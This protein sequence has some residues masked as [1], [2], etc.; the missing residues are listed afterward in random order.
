MTLSEL[1]PFFNPKGVVIV[2]A[3]RE[4]TKLGYGLARNLV[5]CGYSGGIHFVN[6]KG[7]TLLGRPIYPSVSQVPDPVDLAVLLTPPPFVPALLEECGQRGIRAAIVASGGFRETGPEGAALEKRCL[8]TARRYGIRFVGPNCVGTMDTHLPV[9]TTFLQPPMPAK[10]EVAFISHSGAIVAAIIDWLRG[11][12]IGLSRLASLGNQTDVNET[13]MLEL[14]AEDAHTRVITLYLESL[15]NGPR[16]IQTAR[17]VT[18]LKPVIALKVGRFESG[19]KAAASHTGALAGSESAFDAAFRQSGVLRASTTEEMFQWARALAWCPLPAG[20]ATAVLTNAGGP[21]VTAAD[22]LELNGLP[23]AAL[24]TETEAA[25][26]AILPAAAS[27]HN[28]VD[29]LASASPDDYARSLTILLQDPGVNN[30]MVIFPPPPMFSAGSVAK[31][32]IPLIQASEKPVVVALMGSKMIQEA[33]EHFRASQVPE[34]R[35]PE[36]AASALAAVNRYAE[37]RRQPEALPPVLERI[38]RVAAGRLL[39]EQPGGALLEPTA[40]AQLLEHY[41]IKTVAPILV[42]SAAE[43]SAVASRIGFPVVV[44]VAAAAI[45]HKSDVGGVILNIASPEE[46]AEAF[47]T[48]VGRARKARPDAVIEGAHLQR[49]LPA[50]QETITGMVRDPLFGPVVMFGSGGVE[51]EGLKDVAFGLAPLNLDEA[52]QMVD[53]TW[54]GRKLNGFRSLPPADRE[55]VLDTLLRLSRLSEDFPQIAEIEI[56]PLRVLAP[57]EGAYALDVRGRLK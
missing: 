40:A 32:I 19:Q 6:P 5:L 45:S 9:D 13:D 3:S 39:E 31:A 14:L 26:K 30:V 38:D 51:V 8:E 23:L 53:S 21:G 4:P 29:M 50:G 7:D 57:G 35:F 36:A 48:V 56:N 43:A 33:L 1:E 28:P 44:K 52:C 20:R 24:S 54:A 18:R 41:G 22:A 2:G 15:S 25:L 27:V 12:G 16:F 11:E 49:M 42:H 47:T 46:A 37:L 10:G 34:Y 55:A 17:R